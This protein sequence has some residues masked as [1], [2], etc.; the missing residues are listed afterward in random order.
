[1][2]APV[3]D[4]SEP[5]RLELLGDA[6]VD[7]DPHFLAEDAA[8]L[9]MGELIAECDWE[10]RTLHVMGKKSDAAQAYGLG[11][12]RALSLLRPDSLSIRTRPSSSITLESD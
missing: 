10:A 2:R 6:W 9:L 7:Y 1:M 12:Q 4:F 8:S 5:S 11:W 3:Y